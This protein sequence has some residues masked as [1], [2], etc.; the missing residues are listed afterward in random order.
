M[1]VSDNEFSAELK[2]AFDE[3]KIPYQLVMYQKHRNNLAE[4]TI[5]TYK[6]SFKTGL[7]G[8]DPAFPMSE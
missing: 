5:K 8:T 4:R 7:A 2:S 3:H 6:S 1:M